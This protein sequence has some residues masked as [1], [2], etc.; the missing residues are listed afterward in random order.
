MEF[1][2]IRAAAAVDNGCMRKPTTSRSE[3]AAPAPQRIAVAM[4]GG[5]DSNAAAAW[6]VD[7][8]HAVVGLTA[9]MWREGSRCCAAEDIEQARR[10]AAFLGIPHY[11]VDA[12]DVFTSAVVEPFLSAY[13]NGRT[14]SP[15]VL[16]N[17]EV[18]FGFLATRARQLQ[19][20]A[21]A[22]GH[23]ARRELRPDG[24]HLLKAFDRGKDQSYFLHR[25]S[26]RQLAYACFPLADRKKT[27][28]LAYNRARGLPPATRPESQDL[29]FV[30]QRGLP[31][32]IELQRP[33]LRRR[34]AI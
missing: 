6:L 16:C 32:F 2:F 31:A 26:Q 12:L 5:A 7:Q 30:P 17:A 25:L 28:L 33:E 22:T 24:W 18:K 4:S 15:C 9:R 20:A 29:C 27:D 13:A 34:G 21:L 10:V 19:C 8:G 14:P 3:L 11:V 1:T 23:Y